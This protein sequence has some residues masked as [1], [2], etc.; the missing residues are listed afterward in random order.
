M[1]RSLQLVDRAGRGLLID[2]QE[3]RAG[4]AAHFRLVLLGPGRGWRGAS[5][6]TS[7]ESRQLSRLLR[8]EEPGSL[9]LE[10]NGKQ[11]QLSQ[12]AVG[13]TRL[14]LRGRRG[15]ELGEFELNPGEAGALDALL[16]W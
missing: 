1:L 10:E 9:T 13:E 3:E 6:L 14:E 8:E 11:L 15:G 5:C 12:S 4:R 2:H 16:A 7:G